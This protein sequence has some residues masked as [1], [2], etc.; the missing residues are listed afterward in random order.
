MTKKT[1]LVVVGKVG[2]SY[3]V[4]GWTRINSFTENKEDIFSYPTWYIQKDGQ[5]QEVKVSE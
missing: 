4:K 2:A 1:E 5:F 3:G